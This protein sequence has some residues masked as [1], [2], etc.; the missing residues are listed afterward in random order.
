MC[1]QLAI[2]LLA[3]ILGLGFVAAVP[4]CENDRD[5]K[6]RETEFQEQYAPSISPDTA[7]TENGPSRLDLVLLGAGGAFAMS[8]I[9]M[10]LIVNRRAN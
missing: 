1:R 7:P 4:A 6:T 8:G 9:V 5:T 2:L 3:G 10:G